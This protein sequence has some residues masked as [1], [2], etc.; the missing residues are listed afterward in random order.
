VKSKKPSVSRRV[1][2]AERAEWLSVDQALSWIA[3]RSLVS[4]WDI[5]IYIN[6]STWFFQTPDN[7]LEQL[8]QMIAEP[9]NSLFRRMRYGTDFEARIRAAAIAL[10]KGDIDEAAREKMGSVDDDARRIID[11][12][13]AQLVIA[14][15]KHARIHQAAKMLRQAIASGELPAFGWKRYGANG[16]LIDPITE[17]RERIPA[18]V[19][20]GPV[21]VAN[22][23]IIPISNSE[24]SSL[25]FEPLWSGIRLPSGAVMSLW[26]DSDGEL[27]PKPRVTQGTAHTPKDTPAR[28]PQYAPKVLGAWYMTRMAGW[29]KDA[30]PPTEQQDVIA[31]NEAFE[32]RVPRKAVRDI[33]KL[34]APE[35]WLKSGPRK[36]R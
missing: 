23:G 20:S 29:P 31:A 34:K 33:R 6:A 21:T 19:C 2:P 30:V 25:V 17:A 3:F 13:S 15:G 9:P 16:T 14:K 24:D 1:E 27:E 7:V 18:A 35:S 8:R 26:P 28:R 22:N 36:R 11:H 12:L 5:D 10:E 4:N 32:G